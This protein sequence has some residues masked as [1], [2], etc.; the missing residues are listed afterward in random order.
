MAI[1][2]P[3]TLDSFSNPTSTDLVENSNPALDHDRQHSDANDAIEALEAKV[4][5]DNSAVTTTLDYK[6]KST[7]SISPGHKH[8][9]SELTDGEDEVNA[10]IDAYVP[11]GA[12][13][14]YAG[15][16]A[17]TG[18]LL[19]DGTAVSRTTYSALFAVISTTYG[20]GDGS[21]TFNVPD[22]RGRVPIG[23]GTGTGGGA[24]GT[25]APTGGSALT[26]I[27][28]STWKGAETHTLTSAEMPAHKHG[29]KQANGSGGSNIGIQGDNGAGVSG[30]NLN[31]NDMDNT[32]G[33]GAHNN[34]QP[35]MGLNFIIKT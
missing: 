12:I 9:F 11:A 13:Q 27:A 31:A 34:I 28:R 23:V 20:V 7:S 15:S 3:T 19:C 16:A 24:S 8:V 1:T 6:L 32:G 4:G 22:L 17:P 21:S 18:F 2:Y 14:L 35:V 30:G 25:G 33:D 10:L 29:L 26:A 5:V